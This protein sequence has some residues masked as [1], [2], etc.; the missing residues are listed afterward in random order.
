MTANCKQRP[1]VGTQNFESEKGDVISPSN[2][3]NMQYFPFEGHITSFLC[4]T[5]LRKIRETH[6]GKSG[7]VILKSQGKSGNLN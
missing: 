3:K 7:K 1:I 4:E 5:H 2:W 6:S